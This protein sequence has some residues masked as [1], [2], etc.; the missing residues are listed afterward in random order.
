MEWDLLFQIKPLSIDKISKQKLLTSM[1]TSSKDPSK[2][3]TLAIAALFDELVLAF[4][5]SSFV[6]AG[7]N[8]VAAFS[9]GISAKSKNSL[10]D[11]S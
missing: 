9:P 11:F 10:L 8:S 3:V 4:D 6:G 1:V 7:A 2:S 5:F